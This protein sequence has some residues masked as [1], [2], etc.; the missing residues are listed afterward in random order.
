MYKLAAYLTVLSLPALGACDV[1]GQSSAQAA[2]TQMG[3]GIAAVPIVEPPQDT[4]PTVV[5][6][7]WGEADFLVSPSP[8]GRFVSL[9]DWTTGDVALRNLE[10]GEIRH[11]T[12]NPAPWDPG[13]AVLPRLSP[14]GNQIVYEWWDNER[15]GSELRVVDRDGS[16]PRT[17]LGG[18]IG[19]FGWSPDGRFVLAARRVE[20]QSDTE[21]ILVA[22][23]DGSVT[24]LVSLGSSNTRSAT[25]SP[26]GR[27]VVYDRPGE[28]RADQRDIFV[29]GVDGRRPIRI[30]DSMSN[31]YVLGWAPS[32]D[33]ILF[34]SDRTGTPGVWLLPVEDGRPTGEPELVLP[35][36]WGVYPVGFVPDG[37]YYYAVETGA[38]DIYVATLAADYRSVAVPPNLATPR[39]LGQSAYPAWSPDGRHLAY[40]RTLGVAMAPSSLVIRTLKPIAALRWAPDG[41]SLVLMG[42]DA[43]GVTGIYRVDV[44]TGRTEVLVTERGWDTG[45]GIDLSPDGRFLYY[46][47]KVEGE[48]QYPVR[49]FRK[50]LNSGTVEEV[51]K[52]PVGIV[53]N[54]AVSPDGSSLAVSLQAMG[55]LAHQ[56][57][58]LP[59]AGGEA[60]PLTPLT[61]G[62]YSI[63]WTPDGKA[64]LYSLHK[65]WDDLYDQTTNLWRVAVSGGEPEL[66]GLEMEGMRYPRFHPD[67]RRVA[68]AAG[69]ASFELWVMEDF[70]PGSR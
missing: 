31:D 41:R 12:H 34:C 45:D 6:R 16:E 64:I 29:I 27:F 4:I 9:T 30:V 19:P 35:D 13:F 17:L 2:A 56:L 24:T 53:R 58:V 63:V 1:G 44:Q 68:F 8:D 5:R 33:H 25:F 21:I 28:G 48:D 23:A 10:T 18:D 38:R 40:I 14:D 57:V 60:Q 43:T 47:T 65:N 55:D 7:V 61:G 11:V 42:G 39:R 67:G 26:D 36:T 50:D 52:P 3:S 70:L 49:V 62:I 54:V 37:R 59:A 32:G 51:F 46:R 15:A 69:G 66:V 20:G 22:I